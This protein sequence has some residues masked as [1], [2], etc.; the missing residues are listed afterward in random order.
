MYLFF[1]VLLL[2][3]IVLNVDTALSKELPVGVSKWHV[4]GCVPYIEHPLAKG[5]AAYHSKSTWSKAT[6]TFQCYYHMG[7][8]KMYKA[9]EGRLI[10]TDPIKKENCR[11]QEEESQLICEG[12]T[13]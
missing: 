10:I 11:D 9:P 13:D 2:C 12:K 7:K 1:R 5:Y 4:Y 3:G 6:G 8:G